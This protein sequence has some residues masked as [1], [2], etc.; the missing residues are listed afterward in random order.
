MKATDREVKFALS[1][2]MSQR[3]IPIVTVAPFILF[4]VNVGAS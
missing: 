4:E 3:R 1:R 2:F